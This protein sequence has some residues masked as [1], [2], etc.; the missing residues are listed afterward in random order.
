[1]FV[2]GRYEMYN[3]Y[4]SDTKNTAYDYTAV[5]RMAAGINYYPIPQ[6]AVKAEFSKRFLKT[7][8]ND[9]PSINIG[10]AYE[11]WFDTD[12][13]KLA[14]K[15]RQDYDALQQRINDLQRQLNEL[16]KQ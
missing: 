2:F 3:P 13:R 12:H 4:A 1:M 14:Q 15:E 16:K 10:V 6:V 8:Y 7:I 5:K 9:E 11:G